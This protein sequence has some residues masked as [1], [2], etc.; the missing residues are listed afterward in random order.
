MNIQITGRHLEIT[1]AMHQFIT[2]KFS[3]LEKHSTAI[4]QCHVV[5]DVENGQHHVEAEVYLAGSKIF[6]QCK[7]SSAYAAVD[8]LID[9]LDRQLIKHK[10]K[11]QNHHS[12]RPDIALEDEDNRY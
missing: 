11:I 8:V 1:P 3:R 2:E 4:T 10:E 5:I 9:K 6:A 7:E 12:E